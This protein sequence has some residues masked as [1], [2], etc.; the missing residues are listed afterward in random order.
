[1]VLITL[2]WIFQLENQG[3]N[4]LRHD[5]FMFN[6]TQAKHAVVGSEQRI[7]NLRNNMIFCVCFIGFM[8]LYSIQID[9][10]K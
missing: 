5:V 4:Q 7:E 2:S 9:G 8:Q 3:L 1:M 10:T 6:S